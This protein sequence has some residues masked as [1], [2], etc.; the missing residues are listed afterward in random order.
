MTRERWLERAVEMI[1]PIFKEA[2]EVPPVKV[3]IGFPSSGGVSKRRILGECWHKNATTDNVVQIYLNPTVEEI[4]GENGMLAILVHELI[5][6]MG[7]KGHGK[8]FTKVMKIV[9]LEGKPAS[10]VAGTALISEL[11]KIEED[12]N[13]DIGKCPQ[14]PIVPVEL[15]KKKDTCRMIKFECDIDEYIIRVSKKCADKAT[16]ICPVCR[17]EM[18]KEVK[19]DE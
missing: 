11:K 16:P 14:A 13:A 12:L 3:A 10:T 7:I 15:E 1:R 8:E 17:E 19:E 18:R 5:H 4:G 6:A 2:G 9:G